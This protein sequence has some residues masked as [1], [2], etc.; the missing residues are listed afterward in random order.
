M[1]TPER[2]AWLQGCGAHLREVLAEWDR[3]A[4]APVPVGHAWEVVRMEKH[5]GWRTVQRLQTVGAGVGPVLLTGTHMGFLVPVGTAA[6]WNA[7]NTGVLADG[8]FLSA[9]DPAVVAPL[10]NRC[11]TWVI[12]P[13]SYVSL[14]DPVALLEAYLAAWKD[15]QRKTREAKR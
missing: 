10:T 15:D 11:R 1:S 3:G 8:D 6:S 2:V 4:L 7:P 12:A 14:N 13:D 5:L 9:P